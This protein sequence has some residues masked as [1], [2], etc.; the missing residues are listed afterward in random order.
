MDQ[1]R[2][3]V[4]DLPLKLADGFH[5]RLAFNIAYGAAH[6]DDGDPGFIVC[7]IPIEAALDLVGDVRDD[8]DR[9]AAV[10]APPFLLQDGPENLSGGDVGVPVQIFINETLVVSQIQ[11]GFRPVL[12]DEDL[13]MLDRVHGSRVDIDVGIEL[14]HGHLIS[15]GLEKPSQR[16]GGDPLAESGYYAACYEYI[17]YCHSVLLSAVFPEDTACCAGLW[18]GRIDMQKIPLFF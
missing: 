1:D 3:F 12:G 6:L 14:L 16:R 4:A 8:L 15:A 7:E 10:I 18:T 11:I 5:K 13:A 9:A 17:F 2:V